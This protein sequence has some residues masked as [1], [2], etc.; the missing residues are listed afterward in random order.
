MTPA[1]ASGAKAANI[2]LMESALEISA[3]NENGFLLRE[4]NTLWRECGFGR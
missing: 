3:L 2:D 4:W 1:P